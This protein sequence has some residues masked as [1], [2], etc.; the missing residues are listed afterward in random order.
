MDLFI[1]EP[2]TTAAE[3]GMIMGSSDGVDSTSTPSTI[4]SDNKSHTS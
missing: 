3:S 2:V 1:E 4:V